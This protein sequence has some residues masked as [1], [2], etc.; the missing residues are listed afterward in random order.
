MR[1][2]TDEGRMNTGKF[3]EFLKRLLHNAK[4]PVFLIVDGY[5]THRARKV[6]EFVRKTK[7]K[8]RLFSL[9]RIRRN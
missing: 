9:P 4:R 8:L 2:M 7:G 3:I 1:F 5:P 6:F